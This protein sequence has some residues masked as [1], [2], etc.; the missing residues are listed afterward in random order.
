MY[1]Y[2]LSGYY[3]TVALLSLG[4]QPISIKQVIVLTSLLLSYWPKAS[5]HIGMPRALINTHSQNGLISVSICNRIQTKLLV[6][7]YSS[8]G[9]PVAESHKCSLVRTSFVSLAKRKTVQTG[10]TQT[11]VTHKTN[12]RGKCLPEQVSFSRRLTLF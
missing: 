5:F 7:V 2:Q 3:S 11:N 10:R 4:F 6:I 9:F 12:E 8:F 1:L